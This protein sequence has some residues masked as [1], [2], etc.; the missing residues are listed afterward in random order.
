GRHL[1]RQVGAADAGQLSGQQKQVGR[2]GQRWQGP[3]EHQREVEPVGRLR[4][5]G[6]IVDRV[7]EGEE[8]AR[9]DLESEVQVERAAA[10]LLGVEVD[11]P[12]LAQRVGLDEVAL[13]VDVEPV[14]DRVVLQLGHVAGD[15]D[16]GHGREAYGL[17]TTTGRGRYPRWHGPW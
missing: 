1:E 13:V 10:P 2:V 15:V 8:H 7:L 6:E 16:H 9:V 14:V 11:L 3:R 12:D 4:V 17:P 5:L